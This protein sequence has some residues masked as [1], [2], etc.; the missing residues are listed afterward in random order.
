MDNLAHTQYPIH[1]LLARRWS[2]RAFAGRTV[3]PDRLGSL[4]EAAR[5]AASCYNEQPWRFLVAG[6]GQPQAYEDLLSCLME[7]NQVWAASAPVLALCLSRKTFARNGSPN[8]YHRH[9]LGL[10]TASL[11]LQ[12][13]ALDLYVHVMAGILPDKARETFSV[14]EEYDIVTALA[15]G[16]PGDLED[17]PD[18]LQAAEREP[19]RR[20]PLE[21][22]VF[23]GTW[24]NSADFT[25]E[26][27]V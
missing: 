13:T 11:A 17:L 27:R 25:Q 3:T 9:D 15:I 6:K 1:K 8:A 14:P 21:D 26:N 20:M 24:G 23:S 4:F 5:W 2:P 12:A 22:L 19:R 10:A 7:A 16:Y 18:T